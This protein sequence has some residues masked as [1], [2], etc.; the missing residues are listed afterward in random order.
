MMNLNL[1]LVKNNRTN[2]DVANQQS[3]FANEREAFK[4][5]YIAYSQELEALIAINCK[6]EPQRFYEKLES[7]RGR[8]QTVADHVSKLLEM[9]KEHRESV[10]ELRDSMDDAE[11]KDE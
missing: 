5:D 7:V 1:R 10:Q 2:A 8:R 4:S 3:A 6:E 9:T 11:E